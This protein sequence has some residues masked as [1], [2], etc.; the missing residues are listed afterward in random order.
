MIKIY[1][2]INNK[3][4]LERKQKMKSFFIL[5]IL[6]GLLFSNTNATDNA[7]FISAFRTEGISGNKTVGGTSPDYVSLTE[8][9]NSVT[10]NGLSGNLNL[11]LQAGYTSSG[12]TFPIQPPLP[13]STNGFL[14]TVYPGASGLSITSPD[15]NGTIN[16]NGCTNIIFDGR[17]NAAGTAKDLGIENTSTKGY[18]I[19]FINDASNN[20]IKYC[21]IKGVNAYTNEGVIIFGTTTG[22]TGN[23]NN[24]INF[25]DIRDGATTPYNAVYALGTTTTA[26]K[27]NSGD[28]ISNCDIYNFFN[29]GGADNG[30][31]ISSG[32]TDWTITSNHFY[33][34]AAR[35]CTAGA[36]HTAINVSNTS[37]NNFNISGNFAGGS[38]P[39]CTGSPWTI[40]G[41]FANR[42]AGIYLSVGSS[43]TSGIQGNTIANFNFTSK[44]SATN[45]PGWTGIYLDAGNANIGTVTGN[46]IGSG[47]GNGSITVS[48]KSVT[49]GSIVGI[50][51]DAASTISN[52]SNNAIGSVIITYTATPGGFYGVTTSNT[53]VTSLIISNNIIGSTSTPNS[54]QSSAY[55]GASNWQVIRGIGVGTPGTISVINN[56]IANM[57]NGYLPSSDPVEAPVLTGIAIWAGSGVSTVTGNT[58][59]NLTTAAYI[60]GGGEYGSVIGINYL[61]TV[62]GALIS[63][64]TIYNLS[65]THSSAGV[66]VTGIVFVGGTSG[67][68]IIERNYIHSLYMASTNSTGAFMRGISHYRLATIRNNIIRLGLD[69]SGNSIPKGFRIVGIFFGVD[70]NS[71]S[72]AYNNSVYIGGTEVETQTGGTY[73]FQSEQTAGARDIR[74]NIFVNARSN[75]TTGGKHYAVRVAGTG[76]NPSGLTMNNNIY[77]VSGTGCVLGYYNADRT[78]M[79]NWRNSTGWDM[80]S[81]FGDPNFVNPTAATPDLHLQS[82]SPAE[83]S[84]TNIASVTD[85]FDGETRSTLTPSDIGADAGNYTFGNDIFSPVIS[86]TPLENT[87]RRSNRTLYNVSITDIGTGLPVT[88]DSVPRIW[89]RRSFPSVT[90]WTSTPGTLSSGTGNNGVWAFTIDY[91]QLGITAMTGD[92]YQYYITAQDQNLPHNISYTPFLGTLHTN[93]HTQTTSPTT[94]SSYTLVSGLTG[95]FNVGMSESIKSLTGTGGLFS[96]INN[97]TVTGDITVTIK[98]DLSETGDYA[99]NQ[100]EESG[101]TLTIKPGGATEKIISGNVANSLIRLDGADGVTIDGSYGGS[102]RYLVFRNTNESC[103]SISFLNHASN[104]TIKNCIAEGKN[105]AAL[106]GVIIFV[107]TISGNNNVLQN[108]VIRDS[109]GTGISMPTCG[110]YIGGICLNLKIENN[111][112]YNVSNSGII[113]NNQSVNNYCLKNNNIYRFGSNGIFLNSYSSGKIEGNNIY[114]DTANFLGVSV[115]GINIGNAGYPAGTVVNVTGNIIS[116]LAGTSSAVLTGINHTGTST[117]KTTNIIN[118]VVNI[119][120]ST[121]TTGEIS[122][123]V[124]GTSGTNANNFN[125][126]NNSVYLGGTDVTGSSN[127]HCFAIGLTS[128]ANIIYIYNN[129]F[130][131]A[132]SNG[133]GTGK[134]LAIS[135]PASTQNEMNINYNNLYVSGTNGNI[136]YFGTTYYESLS[137][138]QSAS[139]YDTNSYSADPCYL[140]S[141]DLLPDS[142]NLGCWVLNGKGIPLSAVI[143]DIRGLARSTTVQNGPVDIG[144]YEFTPATA[145]PVATPSGVPS[146][147]NTTS[148]KQG[149]K[150]LLEIAWGTNKNKIANIKEQRTNN[151]V[152]SENKSAT[153]PVAEPP[154]WRR[155]FRAR[156]LNQKDAPDALPTTVNVQYFSGEV[157]PDTSNISTAKTGRGYWKIDTDKDPDN[158]VNYKFYWGGQELGNITDTSKLILAMYDMKNRVW[159][160]FEKAE[161]GTG[162]SIVNHSEK[163]ITVNG[164]TRID[165]VIFALTSSDQPLIR[166]RL[167]LNCIIAG[168]WYDHGSGNIM[169]PDSVKAIIRTVN[170]WTA[171]DTL[172]ILLDT[173]GY[174]YGYTNWSQI[175]T[176]V[177]YYIVIEHRNSLQTWSADSVTGF[178]RVTGTRTYDFTSAQDKAYGSNL[179]LVGTKWCIINGDVSRDDYIDGSDYLDIVNNYDTGGQF[180]T[181]DTNGDD[182]IDGSDYLI[183][184]NNYDTGT[185]YPGMSKDKIDKMKSKR[186]IYIKNNT[187][188]KDF[189]KTDI[190]KSNK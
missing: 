185:I 172:K 106:S 184:V 175:S 19:R 190:Y 99:L 173:N 155:Q 130:Y 162:Y 176:G 122:G 169:K 180:L 2:N 75:A 66:Q 49:M 21:I 56:T 147:G 163:S 6:A 43:V 86:Y 39:N 7:D 146:G 117:Y 96:I 145:P 140:L 157:P 110:I 85:D 125:V 189:N 104:D 142:A 108:C 174:G 14:I 112:I 22:T 64:N 98:S 76:V 82:N 3:N 16:M 13:L 92:V 54:V 51:C 131:N 36:I 72:S 154:D 78:T 28:T 32:N 55:T 40:A 1:L 58:I 67:T 62:A 81:G 73:A 83:G 115:C 93:V 134:H 123:I 34:T 87:P 79:H 118:N 141:S 52:I 17:V 100:W 15:T 57:K 50:F 126:F 60:S 111:T 101:Y 48:F 11:I 153:E 114:H 105:T 31:L 137:A 103:P 149:E 129:S 25:C 171:V 158:P 132:R 59:Y 26:A 138:W 91:S 8:A 135:L 156:T 150:K 4:Y 88:G 38:G 186:Q 90:S 113:I 109:C 80:Q 20:V 133:L 71:G 148:Y 168:F 127:T 166:L 41:D 18:A 42:F 102:G 120:G 116:D 70:A 164:L 29:A 89:Y 160:P 27:N 30:I 84:G 37:G 183:I 182:Y 63:Q 159:V 35:T 33:Q 143:T 178:S 151:K 45:S 12:E 10:T 74:N 94:P 68:N 9:F 181:P 95:N 188:K 136:G 144:A 124:Y 65:N 187:L 23:D 77:Y 167:D 161:T 47:T 44:H 139:K 128:F 97:G 24:T 46:T 5:I 152:Q 119:G 107:S 69:I 53:A 177:G 121:V 170:P 179:L 165:S 61:S